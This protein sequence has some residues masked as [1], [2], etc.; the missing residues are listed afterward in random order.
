MMEY[1]DILQ[2]LGPCGLSCRK[3][4]A[5]SEGDIR[6][7]SAELQ[8]LL[9]DFDRY[10]ERF[11]GFLPVFKSYPVFYAETKDAPRYR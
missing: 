6:Q 8:R 7:T 1:Q 9:E 11:S 4:L 3:C 10:A 2:E 5:Y